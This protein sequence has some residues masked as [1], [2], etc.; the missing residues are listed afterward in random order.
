MEPCP[1]R[2]SFESQ[3]NNATRWLLNE[4]PWR[5]SQNLEIEYLPLDMTGSAGW[6]SPPDWPADLCYISNISIKLEHNWQ[7]V[8]QKQTKETAAKIITSFHLS[9]F[10]FKKGRACHKSKRR[11]NRRAG[12]LLPQTSAKTWWKEAGEGQRT[13]WKNKERWRQWIA[14]QSNEIKQS[15][16]RSERKRGEINQTT[17]L[18]KKWSPTVF[19]LLFCGF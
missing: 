8:W 5:P 11:K 1:I 7:N 9:Q 10:W 4:Q 16:T 19:S 12:P 17:H 3:Y 18:N 2:E 6:S 14:P 15:D 13:K